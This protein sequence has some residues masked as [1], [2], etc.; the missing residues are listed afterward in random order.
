QPH[1]LA[2]HEATGQHARAL[3][4][5]D[6]AE[7]NGDHPGDETPD[8]HRPTLRG[9]VLRFQSE[10]VLTSPHPD[11]PPQAGEGGA[12]DCFYASAATASGTTTSLPARPPAST[13]ARAS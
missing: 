2:G 4:D 3:Q 6:R 8:S 11:P 5:P 7:Q 12:G 1:G 13:F 10:R 9:R